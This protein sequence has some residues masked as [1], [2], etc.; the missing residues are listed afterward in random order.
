VTA[1][2]R[3]LPRDWAG[4]RWLRFL[5]GMAMLALALA[6][7]VAPAQLETAT[8]AVATVTRVDQVATT[9]AAAPAP[10]PQ[11]VSAPLAAAPVRIATILTAGLTGVAM[12]VRT[13]RGPPAR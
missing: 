1:V 13:V 9:P 11:L 7:H 10:A 6:A 3:V 2:A 12:R 5:A 4:R 8:P